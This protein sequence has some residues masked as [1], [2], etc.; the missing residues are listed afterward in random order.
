MQKP[1]TIAM[2]VSAGVHAALILF[3]VWR[4]EPLTPPPMPPLTVTVVSAGVDN[5]DERPTTDGTGAPVR[6]ADVAQPAAEPAPE[7]LPQSVDEGPPVPVAAT[8][9]L[10]EAREGQLNPDV[11]ESTDVPAAI[12][13][14]SVRALA[15]SFSVEEAPQPAL[16]ASVTTTAPSPVR[17]AELTARQEK[18]FARRIRDWAETYHKHGKELDELTWRHKGQEYKASFTTLPGGDD[19]SLDRLMIR[20]STEQDGR[21][22]STEMTMKR[23]AFSNYAQFVNRWD[24][25][26]QIH[27]D[28]LDGRFHSNSAINLSYNRRVKPQFR[29]K[30]TTS[31]RRINITDRRGYLRRDEIFLGGLQTGVRSIRLPK[32]FIPLPEAAEIEPDQIREFDEDTRITFHGDGSYTWVSLES[33]LFERRGTIRGPATY[34]IATGSAALHVKGTVDGRVLVYSPKLIEIRGNLVYASDPESDAAADDYIGLVSGRTVSIARPELTGPGDLHIHAAIYAKRRFNVERFRAK[35]DGTLHIY[36]SLT[37]GSL[38]ATEPRYATRIRFDPRLETRRPPGFPVTDRY[39]LETW[40]SA[41]VVE[42]PA[43]L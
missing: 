18:M 35:G 20:V 13:D 41:W 16:T 10:A 28:E 27:D 17:T 25:S 26:V 33:G 9:E 7:P 6:A 14:E 39:E 15:A 1:I 23:L 24:E 5:A 4:A 43:R 29:G 34:L 36:G 37:A 2:T 22:L 3:V 42:E 12:A 31:A 8:I 40:D 19:S 11:F 30:V 21:L 32:H 38:S